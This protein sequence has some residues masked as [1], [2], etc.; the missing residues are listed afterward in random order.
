[1]LTDSP[2][3]SAYNEGMDIMDDLYTP[4]YQS[5]P[6]PLFE[7]TFEDWT[8]AN[9]NEIIYL[10]TFENQ[11]SVSKINLIIIKYL[12]NCIIIFRNRL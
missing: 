8:E 7:P 6:S 5:L 12:I 2:W 10:G 11:S 9:D 4:N 3:L 1:M